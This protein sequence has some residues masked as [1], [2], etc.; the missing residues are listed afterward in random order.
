MR[1]LYHEYPKWESD[2]KLTLKNVHVSIT[3]R[4]KGKVMIHP[5]AFLVCCYSEQ[6]S[7]AANRQ[8]ANAQ[9]SCESFYHDVGV[10]ETHIPSSHHPIIPV[11]MLP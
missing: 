5:C 2:L 8:D 1:P 9:Y 10:S 4:L 3:S 11:Q 6:N 7:K